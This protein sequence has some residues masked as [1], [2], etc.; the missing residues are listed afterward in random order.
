MRR[1]RRRIRLLAPILAVAAC[2]LTAA[3]AV[4][5]EV[6]KISVPGLYRGYSEAVYDEWIRESTY[7]TVWDETRIAVDVIRPAEEGVA[8]ADPLP[9]IWTFHRYHRADVRDGEVVSVVDA[10]PWLQDVLSHGYV[11]AAADVRGSGASFGT[12]EGLFTQAQALDGHDI[13]EW[14]AAQP[15]CDGNVG[16]FGGSYLGMT[17]YLT[18][19]TGPPHLKAIF[20]TMSGIDMYDT[21]YPGGIFRHDLVDRWSELVGWLDVEKPAAPVLDEGGEELLRE[22]L[23]RH[24]GNRDL[25]ELLRGIPLRDDEDERLESPWEAM[26][27]YRALEGIRWTE[28]A[29]YNL[30]GWF[31]AFVAD[32]FRC[33]AS[34]TNPRKL[35]VGPWSHTQSAGLD[36]G[37]EHLRWF[38]YWLKG[39]DNGIMDE[40]PIHFYTMGTPPGEDPWNT[41]HVWPLPEAPKGRVIGRHEVPWHFR[42]SLQGTDFGSSNNGLLTVIKPLDR[43]MDLYQVDYSASSGKPS[44][45]SNTYGDGGSD[46]AYGDMSANDLKGLTYTSMVL[47]KTFELTGSPVVHLW[48]RA[49]VKELDFFVYLEEIDPQ[50]RSHYVTEGMLRSSHRAASDDPP[51]ETFGLPW[52]RG[53]EADL[54][55]FE[56][57]EPTELVFAMYP[58]SNYFDAQNRVRVTVTCADR[59]N[60]ETPELDPPPQVLVYRSTEYPSRVIFPI[61]WREE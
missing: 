48:V 29:V 17:Q 8:V 13:T 58:T 14:L 39:I 31:D 9:V 42:I 54:A 4:V 41:S 52:H 38:D 35:T 5:P 23:E 21:C 32:A 22:A 7:V 51:Y 28:V 59:D 60:H 10:L 49:N 18:A 55:P 25:R 20:P 34:L 11:V 44:R 30:S 37:A 16:M 26:S 12:W 56:S 1:T 2:P 24:A 33:H 36:M 40:P 46:F 57:G 47:P 61:V 27:P 3:P 6:E 19:G 45:W 15:F 43:S 53:A 50:G